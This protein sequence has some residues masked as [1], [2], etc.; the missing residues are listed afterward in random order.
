[1]LLQFLSAIHR[2]YLYNYKVLGWYLKYRFRLKKK[3]NVTIEQ[4]NIWFNRNML[5]LGCVTWPS[6]QR[7]C[8]WTN[9]Q[10]Q[11]FFD[12]QWSARAVH[13]LIWTIG[14]FQMPSCMVLASSSECGSR[15]SAS[16]PPSVL[17][18]RGWSGVRISVESSRCRTLL[19]Q[20]LCLACFWIKPHWV[21]LS[22]KKGNEL[23]KGFSV[24]SSAPRL[25]LLGSTEQL[26]LSE[27]HA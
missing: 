2:V 9:A 22:R 8:L 7:L 14:Y 25:T 1:M 10:G 19:C 15:G 18:P 24:H 6:W 27:V 26:H 21:Q 5:M 11:E 23:S 20:D 4:N 3:Q 12:K 13:L 17:V 16:H